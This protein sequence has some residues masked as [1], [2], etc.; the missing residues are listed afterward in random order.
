M[1]YSGCSFSPSEVA[2]AVQHDFDRG[3]GPCATRFQARFQLSE[4]LTIDTWDIDLGMGQ[5]MGIGYPIIGWVLKM[6]FNLSFFECSILPHTYFN[7]FDESSNFI[8]FWIKQ[9]SWII[10]LYGWCFYPYMSRFAELTMVPWRF[11][12]GWKDRF[13]KNCSRSC[14]HVQGAGC[15]SKRQS[16]VV[17]KLLMISPGF[18]LNQL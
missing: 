18:L 7:P 1:F 17:G 6:G 13:G 10:K 3:N 14:C 2:C 8:P 12:W 5:I 4:A 9:T 16:S 11:V 15:L